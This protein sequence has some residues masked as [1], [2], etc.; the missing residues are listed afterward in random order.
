MEF[1]YHDG[2]RKAAGYK[3]V[4]RDC[5]VRAIAIASG[6]PYMEVYT[7]ILILNKKYAKRKRNQIAVSLRQDG[8]ESPGTGVYRAVYHPYIISLGFRWVA[9]MKIG[10]GCRTHLRQEELPN[11]A[12]L[13]VKVSRHLACVIDGVLYDNHDCSRNGTRCVYGY[14][15]KENEWV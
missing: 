12:I 4:A 13:I 9:T 1:V 15:I 6:K 7:D 8:A 14:Y 2:G 10:S 5:V 3:G 11:P